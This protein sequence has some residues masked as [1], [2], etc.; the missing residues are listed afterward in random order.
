MTRPTTSAAVMTFSVALCTSAAKTTADEP[1]LIRSYVDITVPQP[2]LSAL[3]GFAVYRR[4]EGLVDVA[5]F[6]DDEGNPLHEIDTSPSLRYTFLSPETGNSVSYPGTG[7]L[8]TDYDP[9]GTAVASADGHLTFVHVP[10]S[11]PM[12]I[13]VGRLVFTAEVTGVNADG[14]PVIGPP[15]DVLFEAGVDHG[16]VLGACQTLAP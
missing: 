15:I 8:I 12:F 5:L 1:R 10:G 14:V 4:V 9:D 7:T 2:G 6:V 13:D 3:C 11:A 16:T